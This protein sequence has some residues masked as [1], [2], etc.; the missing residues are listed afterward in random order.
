MSNLS[1]GS[2][3]TELVK[4]AIEQLSKIEE[5]ESHLTEAKGIMERIQRTDIP[6]LLK[7]LGMSEAALPELSIK[8]AVTDGVDISIPEEK[9]RDAFE[10]LAE[11]GY[12]ALV[13]ADVTVSFGAAELEKANDCAEQLVKL[14]HSPTV[15]MAVPPQTL[16]S[17]AKERLSA[18]EDIPPELFNV[19]AYDMARITTIKPKKRT[20]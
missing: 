5:I 1:P 14:Q 12:G 9:R 17:W 18:G 19:R 4:L 6:E 10:W 7:E 2:R 16:K 11:K 8:V 13:R 20:A 15:K 3:L